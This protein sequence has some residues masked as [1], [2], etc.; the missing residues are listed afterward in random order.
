MKLSELGRQILHIFI[1]SLIILSLLFFEKEPVIIILFL[2]FLLSVLLSLLS[3]K[4]N[5]PAVS[6]LLKNFEINIRKTKLPGRSFIFFIAG[7]LLTIKLFPQNIALAAL[8][9]LTFGDS[10]STIM[11]S[12]GKRYNKK[13]FNRF[14]SL[15]G[16]FCGIVISFS[17]AL[18]FVSP[19]IALIASVFGMSAEA[20]S[21]KLGEEEA[22]D[23]LIVPIVAGTA[24]HFLKFIL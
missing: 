7:S 14:K 11:G 1:G 22:D 20:L 13:P 4:I 16:T 21:I 18:F 23:N 24:C 15:Y 8:V 9:V 12:L 19:V 2:V 5:L 3:L 6:W 17:I 10:V